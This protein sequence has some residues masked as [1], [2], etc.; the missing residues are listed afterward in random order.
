MK[1]KRLII[2][3][4]RNIQDVTL[5][6]SDKFNCMYGQNGSG[7]TSFLESL[8]YF[9]LMRSFRSHLI[10]RIIHQ[11]ASDM[12][13]FADIADKENN[14]SIGIQRS[15]STEFKCHLQHKPIKSIAEL[16][17]LLPV[18]LINPDSFS[19]LDG[20]SK[21]RRAMLDWGLFHVEHHPYYKTWLNF[22]RLLKQRNEALKYASQSTEITVWDH[23]LC[24]AAESIHAY[25]LNYY[26]QL[27]PLF[28]QNLANIGLFT[29]IAFDYHAGWHSEEALSTLLK[30]H[31]TKDRERGYTFYGPQRADF[32]FKLN[33]VP[34]QD[35]LS[36]GE[37]KLVITLFKI[38]QVE[39]LYQLKQKESIFLI[40][41][42]PAELGK[43]FQEHMLMHLEQLNSQVFITAIDKQ[44]LAPFLSAKD[45]RMF[46]V[47]Q[48]KIHPV[49]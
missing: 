29:D 35:F 31:L 13:L 26:K 9:S 17:I 25:R 45:C 39:L 34:L 48:G 38:A 32:S 2:Q 47:E 14:V 16:A 1:F 4:F 10:S 27:E 30:D 37:Q 7:K 22:Q 18:V 43:T 20:G 5:E 3:R 6:P 40:D 44:S 33:K 49:E 11:D 21:P 42:L 8:Y 41:D 19:L 24:V 36:R 28:K 46:H 15:L 23:H 12:V